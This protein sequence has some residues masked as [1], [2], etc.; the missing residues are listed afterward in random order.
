MVQERNNFQ[1]QLTIANTLINNTQNRL[2][3][4]NLNNLLPLPHGETLASLLARPTQEQL[5]TEQNR[6]NDLK[7]QN[8][9]LQQEINNLRIQRDNRPDITHVQLNG[10][11]D[12]LDREKD[13]WRK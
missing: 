11:Q 8:G 6:V 5:R 2:G 13:W 9:E 3:I 1:N 12:E 4:N 7:R 10:L